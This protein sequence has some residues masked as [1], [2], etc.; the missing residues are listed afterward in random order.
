MQPKLQ[1]HIKIQR[2]N[3]QTMLM[4]AVSG[5]VIVYIPRG[6]KPNSREVKAF[7]KEGLEQL[8]QHIPPARP[9]QLTDGQLRELLETWCKRMGLYPNRVTFRAMN[10]KWGS[11]SNA[12]NVT[13]NIAL[14]TL[15][16]ELA[17][18]VIVHELAHLAVF[19]HSPNF[20]AFLGRYLPDYDT[21][22]QTLDKIP[23]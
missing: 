6:M 8:K 21:R 3:R 20:W 17:E 5:G 22:R 1:H 10:R 18:Y 15:P 7:I 14:T 23:V 19:D 4:K 13:L 9:Q 11:C 12:G 2:Q 16:L